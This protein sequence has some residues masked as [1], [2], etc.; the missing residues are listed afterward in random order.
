MNYSQFAAPAAPQRAYAAPF[1]DR[2]EIRADADTP[3]AQSRTNKNG[4]TVYFI[5]LKAVTGYLADVERWDGEFDPALKITLRSAPDG[6]LLTISC[7]WAGNVATRF[8]YCLENIDPTRP[9]TMEIAGHEKDGA[10]VQKLFISQDGQQLRQAYT[11]ESPNGKPAWQPVTVNGKVTYDRSDEAAFFIA[12]IE[13][14]RQRLKSA[15]TQLW[16]VDDDPSI[17]TADAAPDDYFDELP[18]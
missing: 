8:L 18:I 16:Q 12:L 3:G 6:D 7:P 4:K 11:K 9:V 15:S 17:I 10:F 2:F 1:R 13:R 14:T 5:G